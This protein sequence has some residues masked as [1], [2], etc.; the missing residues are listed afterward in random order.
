M[1]K[2]CID[3]HQSKEEEMGA[4]GNLSTGC[5]NC[6][7]M[8]LFGSYWY[9]V[10]WSVNKLARAVPTWTEALVIIVSRVSSL[11]FITH[12][13]SDIIVMWDSTTKQIRIVSRFWFCGRFWGLLCIFGSHTFVPISWMCKKQTS[14]CHS[15]TEAEII[16]LDAGLRMDGVPAWDLWDLVIEAFHYS[17]NQ[18]NKSKGQ[19]SQG[20][21]SR[22][23]TLHM[24]NPN[25]SSTS[26]CIW[27]MLNMFSTNVRSSHLGA[28][29]Y[30]FENNEAVESCIRQFELLQN[31]Q[32]EIDRWY[33][34][35]TWVLL[36]F[37]ASRIPRVSA[38]SRFVSS[39]S[40]DWDDNQRR[41]SNNETRVKNPQGCSGLVVW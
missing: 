36:W 31:E 41:K 30:V 20:H 1:V 7:E 33:S 22:N 35:C 15:S 23:T 37:T 12:V 13:N 2:E 39:L 9:I 26:I 38:S 21:L 25:P 28:V 6:S 34:Y 32:I 17:P 8:S 5:T 27:I 3:D 14:V 16:S 10:L 18:I 4:V 11:A 29:W 19:E 40:R 24:K